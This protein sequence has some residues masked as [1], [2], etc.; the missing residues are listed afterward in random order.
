MSQLARA[1]TPDP[2]VPFAFRVGFACASAVALLGAF[3]A[4]R[5]RAIRL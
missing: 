2:A 1:A 5:L 3:S 4:S